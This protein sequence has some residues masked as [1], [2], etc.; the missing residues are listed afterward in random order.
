ME[1][2]LE[3]KFER[4]DELSQLAKANLSKHC[5]G[6]KKGS[7]IILHD[8][9]FGKDYWNYFSHTKIIEKGNDYIQIPV[10]NI[11]LTN[12]SGDYEIPDL[13]YKGKVVFDVELTDGTTEYNIYSPGNWESIY[14]NIFSSKKNIEDAKR[15]FI[16]FATGDE[17]RELKKEETKSEPRVSR[18]GYFSMLHFL[19]PIT[20]QKYSRRL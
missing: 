12:A 13:N 9:S 4:E 18:G 6:L 10:R 14:E 11:L 16:R 15:E 1:K 8:E 7:I 2:D 5:N 20:R 3:Q 19:A 17:K